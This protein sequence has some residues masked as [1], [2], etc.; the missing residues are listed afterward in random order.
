MAQRSNMRFFSWIVGLSFFAFVLFN[1]ANYYFLTT[2]YS[3]QITEKNQIYTQTIALSVSSF[4]ETAYLVGN[5]LAQSPEIQ[6]M[7][8]VKQQEFLVDRF[9]QHGFFE[10][11]IIQRIPD[12]AQ[13][14]RVRG[15]L[16][17]R[18]D[19]WWFRQM[20]QEEKPF[21]SPSFH[22]SQAFPN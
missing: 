2:S 20:L 10:N 16:S 7:V 4:L 11:L 15:F 6:S 12:G 21:L 22:P 8:P 18:P 5:E 9:A 14:A 1:T 13:T 3:A 17:P 19:R